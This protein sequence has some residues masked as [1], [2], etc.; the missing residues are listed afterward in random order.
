MELIG[1]GG[2]DFSCGSNLGDRAINCLRLSETQSALE[3][4]SEPYAP[5]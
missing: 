5:A 2:C 3:S 1:P 4:E